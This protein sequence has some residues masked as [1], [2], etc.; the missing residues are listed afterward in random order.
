MSTGIKK[1]VAK[2]SSEITIDFKFV[3]DKRKNVLMM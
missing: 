3:H 1:V 2:S